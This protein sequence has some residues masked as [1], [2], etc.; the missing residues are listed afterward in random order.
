MR[1]LS[2]DPLA[3]RWSRPQGKLSMPSSIGGK[4]FPP[5]QVQ[6]GTRSRLVH[7]FLGYRGS[8]VPTWLCH[9]GVL[10]GVF[11][12]AT[13]LLLAGLKQN[14]CAVLFCHAC[15]ATSLPLG[16]GALCA[17]AC[18]CHGLRFTV[19]TT[20]YSKPSV[21]KRGMVAALPRHRLRLARDFRG[22]NGASLRAALHLFHG[23]LACL[24]SASSFPLSRQTDGSE[25]V[26]QL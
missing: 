10:V 5:V 15:V 16:L 1:I 8:D 18:C 17:P 23:S 11:C 25:K 14:R 4:A 21:C 12:R 19:S 2:T 20:F 22:I 3:E 9:T 24:F 26:M 7:C 13:L 6:E